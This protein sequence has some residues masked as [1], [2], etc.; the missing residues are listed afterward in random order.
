MV[1]SADLVTGALRDWLRGGFPDVDVALT[2]APAT[3][4]GKPVIHISLADL[5]V[6]AP[7]N[8]LAPMMVLQLG[9]RI[10]VDAQDALLVHRYLGE[11]AFALAE[12]PELTIT[13]AEP[14]ILRMERQGTEPPHIRVTTA[15]LRL[16]TYAAG[17]PVRVPVVKVDPMD[18]SK[19]LVPSADE[20]GVAEAE[21]PASHLEPTRDSPS[22]R[23]A[24]RRG[25]STGGG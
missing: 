24:R 17:P 5:Y 14:V 4:D 9:Y 20:R 15:L 21:L 3:T 18:A 12:N 23:P 1:Q 7:G 6:E 2:D 10:T 25:R 13:D 19:E 22:M 8:R 11:V 16:R